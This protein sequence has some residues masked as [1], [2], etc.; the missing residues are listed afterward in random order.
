MTA[1]NVTA[2]CYGWQNAHFW[3][4]RVV[5]CYNCCGKGNS[6]NS[7]KVFHFVQAGF[8]GHFTLQTANLL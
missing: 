2:G 5:E 8:G 1:F 4:Q 7:G 3:I 6:I